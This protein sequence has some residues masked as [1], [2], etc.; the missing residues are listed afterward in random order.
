MNTS[1]R[2]RALRDDPNNGSARDYVAEGAN[3]EPRSLT[4]SNRVRPGYEIT[5]AGEVCRLK[6]VFIIFLSCNHPFAFSVYCYFF[7]IFLP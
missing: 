4:A 7:G 1:R 3:L 5:T 2:G 6:F